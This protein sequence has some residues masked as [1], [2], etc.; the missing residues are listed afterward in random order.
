[1]YSFNLMLPSNND[2]GKLNFYKILNDV[3]M[4]LTGKEKG[5]KLPS[6]SKK[7]KIHYLCSLLAIDPPCMYKEVK[8]VTYSNYFYYEN[9]S[10]FSP[11]FNLKK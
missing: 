1:M 9:K 8:S 7:G 3:F 5:K 10:R 4:C 11:N 2:T 6:K